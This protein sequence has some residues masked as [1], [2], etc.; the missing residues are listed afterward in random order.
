MSILKKPDNLAMSYLPGFVMAFKEQL[1]L[2]Y[3]RWGDTWQDRP[4]EGIE[5]RIFSRIQ[6]YYDQWRYGGVPMPWL[7]I[8]GNAF[9]G[10]IACKSNVPTLQ[11]LAEAQAAR[12]PDLQAEQ[13]RVVEECKQ[14]ILEQHISHPTDPSPHPFRVQPPFKSPPAYVHPVDP[15]DP[16]Q[17]KRIFTE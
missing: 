7:K 12:H 6:D 4:R 17:P 16:D 15:T 3:K 13:E 1:R 8:A 14:V 2:D 5:V 10:W 9:F 11:V